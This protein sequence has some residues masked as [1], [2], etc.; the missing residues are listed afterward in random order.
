VVD[1]EA[2]PAHKADEI[3]AT[4]KMLERVEDRFDLKPDRLIGD[5]NY[6]TAAI[7]GWMVR[8]LPRQVDSSKLD[9]SPSKRSRYC[10]GGR[11]PSASCGRISL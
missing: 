7:L 2:T 5:T 10:A 6:G 8:K 11:L 4:K 9:C 3:N 1:V